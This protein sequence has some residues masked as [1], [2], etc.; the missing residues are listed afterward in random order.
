MTISIDQPLLQAAQGE[1]LFRKVTIG[2]IPYIFVCYLFNYLDRVNVGFAKLSML[3]DLHMSEANYGFGAGIFFIG[4]I[5][6]GV[7]SNLMLK[8]VGP[9][10]WLAFIMIVWGSLSAGLMFIHGPLAFYALRFLTGAAEAGFFPGLVLYLTSWFPRARQGRALALFMSAI[11]LS[12]VL[13]GPLSGWILTRFSTGSGG[14]VAWQ[15]LF[16]LQGLPTILLGIGMMLLLSDRIEGVRWLSPE[17]KIALRHALAKD[18][19]SRPHPASDSFADIIRNPA[20][21]ALGFL[22]FSIQGG[23]Y[24]ISFW[25]PSIIRSSG[26]HDPAQIGWLSAI[27][28]VLASIVMIVIGRSA[29]RMRER[30]WHLGI[31]MIM[32][33]TGLLISAHYSGHASLALVGLALATSGALTGLPMFWPLSNGY[34]SPGAAAGGLALINSMGQLAGF[35][36]PYLIGWIKDAT[37]STDL[38]L[39]ILAG[40]MLSGLVVVFSIAP[41]RVNH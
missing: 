30:R 12:G 29:D 28:Y 7:P 13:G 9:R 32:A 15:W 37:R 3:D 2:I 36:S 19:R 27:P 6:C 41:G 39:Y 20:I 22:Y 16:L 1:R 11:P 34:L 14:L 40:L 35:A 31:P 5:A 4:Y 18:A 23:V 10:R 21:W 38:A 33:I 25:L 8:K 17:E 26:F 24:A